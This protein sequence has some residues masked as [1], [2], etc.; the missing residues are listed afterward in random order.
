[1]HIKDAVV[2]ITGASGGIGLALARELGQQGAQVVLAA[3]SKETLME[4]EKEIPRSLAVPTDM[5]TAADIAHLVDATI[6]QFGRIDVWVNNA[7]QGMLSSVE[8]IDIADYKD[9]MELNVF[10]VVQAMQ[11]V[12]PHMRT[13]GGGMILNISSMVSKNYY[14]HLGAYA[15]TKYALNALSL[16]ARQELA[17]DHIV[18]SVFHPKMTSTD[19]GKNALGDTYD[20]G[21]GRP[22][23]ERPKW[24]LQKLPNKL[25]P[26]PPKQICK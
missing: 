20:S 13:Q 10:G 15:S 1:M 7:G 25:C 11:M 16:T 18:V 5:R 19:F 23:M 2:V 3:R 22:G 21:A 6:T 26:K 4:L 24:W 8:K 9:M 17:P 12:I 14:P